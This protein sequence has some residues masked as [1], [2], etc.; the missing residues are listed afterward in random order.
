MRNFLFLIILVTFFAQNA[1]CAVIK[2][3]EL[4]PRMHRSKIKLL[5]L[6]NMIH[7]KPMQY[8]SYRE[9]NTIQVEEINVMNKHHI[10]RNVS[11]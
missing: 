5:Y 1:K 4:K 10:I 8:R 9:K 6:H 11:N 3:S 2:S 7:G